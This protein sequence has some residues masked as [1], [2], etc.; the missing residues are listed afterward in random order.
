[1]GKLRYGVTEYE[2]DD[3]TLAHIQVVVGM[4]LRRGENFF[5]SWRN[6]SSGSGRQ[7][8]WIDNGLTLAF[9]YSAGTVPKINREWTETLA[10]SAAS[11]FGL[12]VT[13]ENGDLINISEAQARS[14]TP[15]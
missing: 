12:Q 9:E 14:K 10:S 8:I 11:A 13:D 1:L 4:K 2:L 6:P 3:R 5:L 15:E 7:S